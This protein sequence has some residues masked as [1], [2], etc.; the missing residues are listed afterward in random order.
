MEGAWTNFVSVPSHALT[1]IYA[2]THQGQ[3]QMQLSSSRHFLLTMLS[4]YC[5]GSTVLYV[6]V[7]SQGQ[8]SAFKL[9]SKGDSDLYDYEN[10]LVLCPWVIYVSQTW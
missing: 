3:G 6:G 10:F 5:R 2:L 9:V 4:R 8:T 7:Q 1:R